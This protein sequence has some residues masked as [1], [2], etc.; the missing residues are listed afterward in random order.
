MGKKQDPQL[1]KPK[2]KKEAHLRAG[3]TRDHRVRR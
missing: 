1:Q 3:K 2:D